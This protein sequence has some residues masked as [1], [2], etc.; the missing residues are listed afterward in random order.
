MR[1][2]LVIFIYLREMIRKVSTQDRVHRSSELILNGLQ[3]DTESESG[4]GW[5]S[6]MADRGGLH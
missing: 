2:W 5:N 3:S 6:E 1:I 4:S